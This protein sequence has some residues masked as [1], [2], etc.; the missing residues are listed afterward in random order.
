MEKRIISLPKGGDLEM[1]FTP[2]FC[3][4]IREHFKLQHNEEILDEHLRM[5]IYGS[6]KNAIDKAA[7][8]LDNKTP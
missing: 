1:E 4:K 5:L 3:Q 6:C 2:D 8:D 7:S